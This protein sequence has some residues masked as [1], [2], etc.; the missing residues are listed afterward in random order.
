MG[1]IPDV[2]QVNE[3]LFQR[4]ALPFENCLYR[5]GGNEFAYASNVK[6]EWLIRTPA[7]GCADAYTSFRACQDDMGVIQDIGPDHPPELLVMRTHGSDD[8]LKGLQEARSLCAL[9]QRLEVVQGN[10]H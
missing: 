5:S 9:A 10:L 4:T 2:D 6:P 3:A 7:G 1:C 8:A